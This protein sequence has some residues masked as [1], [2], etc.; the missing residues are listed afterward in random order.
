[1]NIVKDEEQKIL[2]ENIGVSIE[3]RLRLSP[4]A[5]RIYALLILS[6]YEGITFDEIREGIKASKSSISVNINVLIQ[7]G[8]ISFLTKSG[9]RKRY[10]KIAKYSTI[11]SLEIYLHE[12][13]SERL[14]L[15]KINTFN[16]KHH[17]EKFINEKSLGV[18]FEEYLLKKEILVAETIQ[19]MTNFQ[20][21]KT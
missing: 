2:I 11:I 3:N 12:I 4:L 14:M 19:K 17:P 16:K 7:L 5:S 13:D 10:F 1:M 18:I 9:D 20:D 21:T 6:S 15:E 8:Y